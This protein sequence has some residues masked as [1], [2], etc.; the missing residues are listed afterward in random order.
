MY[1]GVSAYY[2]MRQISSSSEYILI[3]D[4]N[5]HCVGRSADLV[6]LGD[7]TSVYAMH[8]MVPFNGTLRAHYLYTTEAKEK[9]ATWAVS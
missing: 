4:P 7:I 6:G 3:V 2:K 5:K 9:A 8:C 1:I